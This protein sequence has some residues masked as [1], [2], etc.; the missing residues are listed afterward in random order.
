[1]IPMNYVNVALGKPAYQSSISKWTSKIGAAGALKL[2]SDDDFGFHTECEDQPWWYVDLLCDYPIDKIVLHN[3]PGHTARAKSIKVETSIDFI[4]WIKIHEGCVYF[5]GGN[6]A[7]P[8]V[9]PLSGYVRARFVRLTLM[10]TR[11]RHLI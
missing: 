8:F 9:L 5:K 1:M 2:N 6:D 3:R 4:N 10:E 7:N 11:V